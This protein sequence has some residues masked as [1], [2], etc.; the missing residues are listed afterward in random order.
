MNS[1]AAAS[2]LAAATTSADRADLNDW[3]VNT[4]RREWHKSGRLVIERE[5]ML[6]EEVERAKGLSLEEYKSAN[7]SGSRFLLSRKLR[8]A[9]YVLIATR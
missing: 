2:A 1:T 8:V 9:I 5:A 7:R 6:L 3:A 4:I